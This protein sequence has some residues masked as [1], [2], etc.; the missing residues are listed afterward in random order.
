MGTSS[1]PRGKHAISNLLKSEREKILYTLSA[2]FANREPTRNK[3]KRTAEMLTLSNVTDT[4]NLHVTPYSQSN[5]YGDLPV[6]YL[7]LGYL[8]TSA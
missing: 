6:E 5:Q 7:A 8:Q 2:I 4:Y 1:S 3:E